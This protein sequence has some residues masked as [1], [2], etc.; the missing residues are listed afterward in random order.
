M[1]PDRR[2]RAAQSPPALHEL[3]SEVMEEVWR[4]GPATVR[5]V[6]ETLNRGPKRR[7]YT[8]VMTTMRRL[9]AKGM[10]T[11]ERQGKA[12]LYMAAMSQE[13][14]LAARAR[15]QVDALVEDYGDAALAHFSSHVAR[16]DPER[17]RR[18]RELAEE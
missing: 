6:L 7:A 18:L 5:A 4:T 14:Y 1:P 10:L 3:E 16:L 17:L 12:D 2:A 11:R 15:T 8:T 9:H 13:R